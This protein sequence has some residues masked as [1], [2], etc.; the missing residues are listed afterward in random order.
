MKTPPYKAFISYKHHAGLPVAKV[1][2]DALRAYARPMLV[3]PPRIFRDEDHLVPA[4]NLPQLIKDALRNSEYLVLLAS[5]EATQS[6][7]VQDEITIW[8]KEFQRVDR[9]IIVLLAG[10][11]V[12]DPKT[13]EFNWDRTDAL[14]RLL[15]DFLNQV[16]LF[17]DLRQV[18]TL[19]LLDVRQ[20]L[21]KSAIN[22][23]SAAI[24]GIEP[25][26]LAGEET[27]IY[28]RNIRTRNIGVTVLALLTVISFLSYLRSNN[29]LT[30]YERLAD[31]RHLANAKAELDALWPVRPN[32][33]PRLLDWRRRYSDLPK[34][35]ISHELALARL[36]GSALP[37]CADDKL[38]EYPEEMAQIRQL[39]SG[40]IPSI[41]AALEDEGAALMIVGTHARSLDELREIVSVRRT[42][43]FSDVAK[44]FRHDVLAQLVKEL[45]FFVREKNGAIAL[46][47]E[48]L[49]LS[50][51][52]RRAT[53]DDFAREWSEALSR[54]R[55]NPMYAGLALK[56]QLGL[57]PL[58]C[59]PKTQFEEFACWLTYT[60]DLPRR[61]ETGRI[62]LT[63]GSPLILVLVPATTYQMGSQKTEPTEPNYD[64]RARKNESPVTSIQLSAF[65]ISKFE[66]TQGQWVRFTGENPSF[67]TPGF[68]APGGG[69]KVT[70]QHPVES[71]SWDNAA[72]VMRK[73]GL[74]LP[75][76]AQWECAARAGGQTIYSGV[77]EISELHRIANVAGEEAQE[78]WPAD[79]PEYRRPYKDQYIVHSPVGAFEPNAFG[80]YDMTGNVEEWC[81][82]DYS[83]YQVPASA[84]TGLR[85]SNSGAKVDRSGDFAF[86]EIMARV[87]S[88]N[89]IGRAYSDYFLGVRPARGIRNDE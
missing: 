9:M 4:S 8:C 2:S 25:N 48:R 56:P 83:A 34:R 18:N 88:R 27:R 84:G 30:E 10:E 87:A 65:F 63:E 73:M 44:Q 5:P 40:V 53:I 31:T 89:K 75:T 70:F 41:A 86:P 21:F 62:E 69:P 85:T 72:D 12:F 45:G 78:V 80:L 60:G 49:D 6:V 28:K 79:P 55:A 39:E 23:I 46:V 54:V 22:A 19:E 26:D 42:W 38:R 36:R 66:M 47:E 32:L 74:S 24:R 7:W 76:E 51:K 20:P 64:P 14:P 52:I 59:D 33:I 1:I 58:G 35:L 16:P 82:D 61:T 50:S 3:A 15:R 11:I 68:V 71:I 37:Y 67:Y 13:K 17:V 43:R 57:I 81:Q 29:A 77:S